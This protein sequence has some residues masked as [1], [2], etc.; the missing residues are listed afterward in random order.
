[1]RLSTFL[2]LAALLPTALSFPNQKFVTRDTPSGLSTLLSSIDTLES[3]IQTLNTTLNNFQD[4][5][6]NTLTTLLAIQK[7]S[8]A[9]ATDITTATEIAHNTCPLDQSDSLTLGLA[10]L[11]LSP[12]IFSLLSTI[13]AKKPTFDDAALGVLDISTSIEQQLVHQKELSRE[14]GNA[15]TEVLDPSLTSLAAPVTQSIQAAFEKA[16]AVYEGSGGYEYRY[17]DH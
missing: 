3:D 13:V 4:A 15:I 16:I 11:A 8:S 17:V 5:Q 1:M 7:Q 14:L 2:P 12:R 10:T 6:L 9:L